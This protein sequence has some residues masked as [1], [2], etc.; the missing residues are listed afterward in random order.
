[1]QQQLPRHHPRQPPTR[2]GKVVSSASGGT[3]HSSAASSF[4]HRVMSLGGASAA[5]CSVCTRGDSDGGDGG[6]EGDGGGRVGSGWGVGK[7]GERKE[8]DLVMLWCS[9]WLW[10]GSSWMSFPLLFEA[11]GWPSVWPCLLVQ[12]WSGIYYWNVYRINP[13]ISNNDA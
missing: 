10:T 6:R 13:H 2:A 4:R 12:V 9:V 8:G 11:G 7:E 3:P 5:G 1:M